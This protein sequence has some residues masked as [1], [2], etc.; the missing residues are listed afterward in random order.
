M[1]DFKDIFGRE[2]TESCDIFNSKWILYKVFDTIHA[3][4][5][6]AYAFLWSRVLSVLAVRFLN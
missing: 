3:F 4:S 2:T 1:N 6:G 5:T